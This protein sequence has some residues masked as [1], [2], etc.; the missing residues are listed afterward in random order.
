MTSCN[1]RVDISRGTYKVVYNDTITSYIE[2]YENYQLEYPVDSEKEELFL[3]T[4]D[5]KSKYSL[6]KIKKIDSLD[7]LTL[8]VIIDSINNDTYYQRSYI[9]GVNFIY[10]SKIVKLSNHVS[11]IF[12]DAVKEV[13]KGE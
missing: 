5:S 6:E 1:N 11:Q 12:W 2:R 4:W 13:D 10:S 9:E 3:I 8:I 7:Y